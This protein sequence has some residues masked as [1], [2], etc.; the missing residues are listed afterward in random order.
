MVPS[1][2]IGSIV[3]PTPE[4]TENFKLI[5]AG[6]TRFTL[7]YYPPPACHIQIELKIPSPHPLTGTRLSPEALTGER[8]AYLLK[9]DVAL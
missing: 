9:V 2:R 3:T 7:K 6:D 5:F 8:G 1:R 4:A